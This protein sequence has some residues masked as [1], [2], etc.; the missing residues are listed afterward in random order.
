MRIKMMKFFRGWFFCTLALLIAASM[1]PV[2]ILAQA[3]NQ[4][5]SDHSRERVIAR[6]GGK[7]IVQGGTGRAGG[8]VP[9]LTTLAFHAEEK[10]G[11]V[12][13]DF[14]CLALVP[15]NPT[16]PGNGEFTVNAMYVTGK[17]RTA[18]VR[19]NTA[20]LT[21]VVDIT[22]LGAGT[23]VPFKFVVRE[24]GPGATAVLTTQGSP[25]LVFPEIL[26]EGS[27]QVFSD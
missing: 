6:G 1:S 7:T 18:T 8:F 13:G 21:G 2:M 5:N 16:G 17:I 4:S 3:L 12:T 25:E 10:D 26:L 22:G 15:Q 23:D 11:V 9:V 20:T 24:G 14:E 19:G 27:F